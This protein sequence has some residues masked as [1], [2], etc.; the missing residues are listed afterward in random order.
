M[1]DYAFGSNRPYA[2]VGARLDRLNLWLAGPWQPM[3]RK[4]R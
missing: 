1:A 3:V 4:C 2:L